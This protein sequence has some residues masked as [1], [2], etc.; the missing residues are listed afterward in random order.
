M[1]H[2]F[3]Y[4]YALLGWLLDDPVALLLYIVLPFIVILHWRTANNVCFVDAVVSDVCGRDAPF[5]HA[6]RQ[7]GIPESITTVLIIT[8]VLIA[9]YKLQRILRTRS[10]RRGCPPF[11]TPKVA[12]H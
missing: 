10:N 6:G 12:T 9:I 2:H 8:G 3:L 4:T 1:F 5:R 7:L 11:S